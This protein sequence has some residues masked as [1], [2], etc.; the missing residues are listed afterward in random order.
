MRAEPLFEV[1]ARCFRPAPRVT[2]AVVRLVPRPPAAQGEVVARARELAAAAFTR[3]RKTLANALPVGLP[4]G[5]VA[6]RL[7][8]LDLD[9]GM[10]PQEVRLDGWL[11]LARAFPCGEAA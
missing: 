2:S 11:A 1:P 3:R 9:P 4:R 10:R 6:A 7:G 5:E 8:A